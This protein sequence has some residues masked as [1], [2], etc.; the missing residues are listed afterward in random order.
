MIYKTNPIS[1]LGCRV[2]FRQHPSLLSPC[3][4]RRL[5]RVV[6]TIFKEVRQPTHQ[7]RATRQH[8]GNAILAAH[9]QV[10]CPANTYRVAAEGINRVGG[11]VH[12]AR[13][14]FDKALDEGCFKFAVNQLFP[15]SADLSWF[16]KVRVYVRNSLFYLT[17]QNEVSQT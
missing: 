4:G 12:I 15:I 5:R 17:P 10:L 7:L 2:G 8:H 6:L 9:Q 16:E 13:P 14:I 1:R 11:Q 3:Q